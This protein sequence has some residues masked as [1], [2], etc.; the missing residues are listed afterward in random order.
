[1]VSD[2]VFNSRRSVFVS[3]AQQKPPCLVSPDSGPSVWH[4]AFSVT[5]STKAAA[6]SLQLSLL[7]RTLDLNSAV[8]DDDH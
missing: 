8:T 6:L 2:G 1:M 4:T 7:K 5:Q 3:P